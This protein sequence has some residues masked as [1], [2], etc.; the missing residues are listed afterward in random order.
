MQLIRGSSPPPL[1]HKKKRKHK[2]K[3]NDYEYVYL[4]VK[5]SANNGNTDICPLVLGGCRAP[6]E[7]IWSLLCSDLES[8][9]QTNIKSLYACTYLHTNKGMQKQVHTQMHVPFLD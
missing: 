9:Y 3:M 6:R 1:P 4:L 5:C 7:E 8:A 2:C